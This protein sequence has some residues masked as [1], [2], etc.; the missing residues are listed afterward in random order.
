MDTSI[1]EKKPDVEATATPATPED[2]RSRYGS[3]DEAEVFVTGQGGVNFRTVGWIRASMFFLKMTFAAGV[4]SI[5][6]ALYNL[7]AVAGGIFIVFWGLLN[8][9]C[10]VL[11]GQFKLKYPSVHTIADSAYIASLKMGLTKKNAWVV[12]E[13]TEF[14][15]LFT[16]ILCAG[17]STLG[18]S[19][20]LNAVSKHGTC[21]IT[22][23]FVAY[24]IVASVASIRKIHNLGWITWVGFISIVAAI[25][26]VVIAVT[27]RDR[28]A[29]AP[30]TGD[31][32][33]GFSASPPVGA[34]FATAW[35][36]SLAIFSSS[37]NT[38]GFVPV[39]SE[40]RRPQDY[41]KSV[42]VTM[43]WITS[44]YLALAMTVYAYCGKW[45]SSPALGSAGPTIKIISYAIAI[46]G[47]IAGTMICVHVAGKSIF[48]R[49]LR[50]THHLTQNTKTHWAVWLSCTYGT[51][52]LGW[53]LCEAIPFY[54]SLVSLI[55]ALGFGYLG[56]CIPAILWM[57]LNEG[58]RKG[59][60]VKI[61]MYYLHVGIFLLGCLITV[62]GT[63]ANVVSIIDQYRAGQVGSAFSCLDNSNTVAGG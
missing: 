58:A 17:V 60:P 61:F 15:Y 31:F 39:I 51:G 55:G 23:G 52:L 13:I 16:W 12:K 59:T 20:A 45:V 1:T 28:P 3:V 33:L 14:V 32:D 47:L 37:A 44:S 30:Q 56:V 18:F 11:Q 53:I 29:A 2:E 34:T 36:A 24:I 9:Y 46:P 5:P 49:I 27:I 7:G 63:Y 8:T 54:G 22:F 10:A 35:S 25:M 43:A 21:T 48:V 62:G 41:F 50:N 19:I 57:V 4:L 40:M 38:S 26:I 6:A 42:Y